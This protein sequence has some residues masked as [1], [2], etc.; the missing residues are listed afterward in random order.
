MD[1]VRSAAHLTVLPRALRWAIGAVLVG[2]AWFGLTAVLGAERASADTGLG[3]LVGSVTETV[4]GVT[5]GTLDAVG[6]TVEGTLHAVAGTSDQ[7]AADAVAP[8]P[9]AP[10]APAPEPA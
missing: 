6:S 7:P 2:I 8:A 9:E 10:A 5:G 3:G 1:D 4:G